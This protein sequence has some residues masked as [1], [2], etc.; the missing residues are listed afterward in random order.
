MVE[1]LASEL[2]Y[3]ILVLYLHLADCAHLCF[4]VVVV[5]C[6]IASLVDF[7]ERNL[8]IVFNDLVEDPCVL[9][10]P[11][12]SRT[13][14]HH[15]HWCQCPHCRRASNQCAF[16]IHYLCGHLRLLHA[17]IVSCQFDATLAWHLQER[18]PMCG[19]LWCDKRTMCDI[20]LQ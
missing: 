19:R 15:I 16:T 4:L 5:D 8:I 10:E 18:L 14:A 11:L 6:R 17:R 7:I 20:A 3:H 9:L 13:L 2:N 1:V 12:L